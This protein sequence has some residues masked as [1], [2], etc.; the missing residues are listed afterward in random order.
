MDVNQA[1]TSKPLS[2]EIPFFSEYTPHARPTLESVLKDTAPLPRLT[3]L[4][5]ACED[6]LPVMMDLSNPRAGSIL[7]TADACSGK[8]GLLGSILRSACTTS[9]ARSLR[10]GLITPNPEQMGAVMD[11]PHIYRGR[12]G[13]DL[14]EEQLIAQLAD[15]MHRRQGGLPEEP[16]ILLAI[17]DLPGLLNVIEP[18]SAALLEELIQKGAASQVRVIATAESA[19]LAGIESTAAGFGAWLV[20]K[21]DLDRD[22]VNLAQIPAAASTLKPGF[23]FCVRFGDDWV[24]F[25]VLE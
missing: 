8:T 17:D 13:D 5:G 23:Q 18:E 1:T 9:P 25:W 22:G 3:A 15:I 11:L 20:G 4:I 16:A 21:T 6:G 10:I 12:S 19:Q 14:S 2:Q 7:I 24:T